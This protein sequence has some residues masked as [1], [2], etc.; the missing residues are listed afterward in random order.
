MERKAVQINTQGQTRIEKWDLLRALL[1]FLVV[2]GHTVNYY[3]ADSVWM[4]GLFLFIN[5]F[6]MP[7]FL[8]LDGLFSKHNVDGKRYSRIFSYLVAYF[9]AK[10]LLCF[11][12]GI[13]V[14][15]FSF[16]LLEAANLPWYVL[17]LF[18][19]NLAT[20]F[21]SRLSHR[22]VLIASVVL[23]CFVGYDS[24]VGDTLALMRTIVF[25]PFFFAG[26]CLDPGKVSKTLSSRWI[27]VCGLLVLVALGLVCMTQ[28]D[29]VY[30][31]RTLMTGRHSFSSLAKYGYENLVFYGGL[32][33]LGYYGVVAL[34]CA[35]LVA[36]IPN[37][38]PGGNVFGAVGRRSLEVY[39]LHRPLLHILY[40]GF[41]FRTVTAAA[42][43]SDLIIFPIAVLVTVFC[44]LPCWEKPI[45]A[46]IYPGPHQSK[47]DAEQKQ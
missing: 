37:H 9:F 35:A 39:L 28:T 5:S 4:R 26:Y 34:L 1:I 8:F 42:G 10:M 11:A 46:V 25:Y 2:L 27:R 43:V 23:A 44:A 14:H 40:Q 30:F 19:F 7:C 29:K 24:S 22:W 15:E 12:K 31:L 3:T 16:S 33:R 18:W 13:L 17:A 38:I 20:I 21:L 32:L 41:H 36:V 47:G 45:R 6:H